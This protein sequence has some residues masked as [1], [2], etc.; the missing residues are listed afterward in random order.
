M[1][2][3][4]RVLVSI[5]VLPPAAVAVLLNAGAA[6]V[7]LGVEATVSEAVEAAL[8]VVSLF[9]L[10]LPDAVVRFPATPPLPPCGAAV[11]APTS[12]WEVLT[13]SWCAHVGGGWMEDVAAIQWESSR[14]VRRGNPIAAAT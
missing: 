7:V 9:P 8:S 10:V 11:P 3:A 13:P 6:W 1:P 4:V 14:P 12:P 2:T 5:D